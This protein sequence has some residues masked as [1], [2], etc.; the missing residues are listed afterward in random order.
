MTSPTSAEPAGPV[1]LITGGSAGIG[2]GCA[3][4]FHAAGYRVIACSNDPGGGSAMATRLNGARPE[5]AVF[6]ECDVRVPAE[7]TH[8]VAEAADAFGRLDVLINNV[9]ANR[10][11]K[12]ADEYTWEEIDDLLKVNLLPCILTTGAALPHLRRTRGSIVTIGSVTGLLGHYGVSIYAAAK[13]AV[14]AFTKAVAID[15]IPA[16]VRANTV[17]P[18]NIMTAARQCLEDALDD[19]TELHDHIESL[20]WMGRSGLPEEIA[21]ACLFLAGDKAS[22]ITGTELVV[23]GGQEIGSGPKVRTTVTDDGRVIASPPGRA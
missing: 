15:E 23:S 4:V 11:N 20:Q 3:Q 22:F 14:A 6:I 2:E 1:V 7:I 8:M 17:V 19:P 18:G 16:G 5:S 21:N 10:V 13:A 9:G 12:P